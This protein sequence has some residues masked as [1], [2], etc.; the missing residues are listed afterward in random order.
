MPEY[1]DRYPDA[2]AR[3]EEIDRDPRRRHFLGRGLPRQARDP[4]PSIADTR[5][6]PAA[7]PPQ[8]VE[9]PRQPLV[10]RSPREICGDVVEQLRGNPFIDA[11]GIEV[12][13]DG[14]EV[15]LAGTINSLIAVSLARAL[16]SNVPGVGR[17]Q[18]RLRVHSPSRVYETSGGPVRKIEE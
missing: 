1:E 5:S 13:V 15:T 7:R 10:E 4:E 6:A 17:V 2:Y 11:S 9:R 8:H 3:R 18:V 12:T 16:A 14:S